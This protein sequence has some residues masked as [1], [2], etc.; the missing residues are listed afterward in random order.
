[1]NPFL[2]GLD[3]GTTSTKAVA[4]DLEGNTLAQHSVGYAYFQPKEDRREQNPEEIFTAVVEV[5]STVRKKVEQTHLLA[6]VSFSSVM[7][8]LMLVDEKGLPLT[9]LITWADNRSVEEADA[10]NA[11]GSGL[12]FYKINGTATHPM[13]PLCKL[14]W[15]KKNEPKLFEKAYKF[16]GIKEFVFYHLTGQFIIDTSVASATGLF[17][18]HNLSWSQEILDYIGISPERLSEPVSP[19]HVTNSCST[20]HESVKNTLLVTGANDGCLANLGAGAIQKGSLAITVGTSA[21]VRLTTNNPLIDAQARTFCYH[22]ADNYYISGGATN[23]A[24]DVLGWYVKNFMNRGSN[25]YQRFFKEI[26]KIDAGSEGL[27]FLP[28][29]LGERS[30]HFNAKARGVYFGIS[31]YHNKS[32]FERATVEGISYALRDITE[33]LIEASGISVENIIVGGGV[34]KQTAWLQLMA[35]VLNRPLILNDVIEH[36]AYGAVKIG[37]KALGFISDFK[38]IKEAQIKQTFYPNPQNREVYDKGFAKFRRLYQVLK[39][40]F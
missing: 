35:D 16:I 13:S 10:L 11:S 17:D 28:Y 26:I 6:G 40:E 38:D 20:F 14:L 29:L 19:F 4:F 5:L 3:I 37:M 7:H 30:P 24:G 9:N 22:L 12:D 2:I 8:S 31:A 33:V 36:S 34:T 27:L 18:I 15:F 23:N 32:H 1:M 21:A 39:E 25:A